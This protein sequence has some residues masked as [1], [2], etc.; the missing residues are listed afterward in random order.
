L[1]GRSVF[2]HLSR[3]PQ[4]RLNPVSV[5]QAQMTLNEHD[6]PSLPIAPLPPQAPSDSGP[7]PAVFLAI[8]QRR[9]A[10]TRLRVLAKGVAA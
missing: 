10:Q 4:L 1:A 7:V 2:F 3:D 6:S 5:I 9:E 8:T